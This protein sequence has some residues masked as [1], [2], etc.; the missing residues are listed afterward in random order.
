MGLRYGEYG[1]HTKSVI[2]L[3]TR[4]AKFSLS[5]CRDAKAV[6]GLVFLNSFLYKKN[7]LFEYRFVSVYVFFKNTNNKWFNCVSLSKIVGVCRQWN[8]CV[9]DECNLVNW[10][11]WWNLPVFFRLVVLPYGLRKNIQYLES[12]SHSI[13]LL[14]LTG[15]W[16]WSSRFD[17]ISKK[18]GQVFFWNGLYNIHVRPKFGNKLSLKI[19]HVLLCCISL[20]DTGMEIFVYFLIKVFYPIIEPPMITVLK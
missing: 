10:R 2:R 1:A 5:H 6:W 3:I 18:V 9:Q 17:F 7:I 15:F 11:K 14:V 13:Y 12:C 19:L 4:S 16:I 8:K 20:T